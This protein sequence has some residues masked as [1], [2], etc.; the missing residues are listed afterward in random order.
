[1]NT[2]SHRPELYFRGTILVPVRAECEQSQQYL[3]V[4]AGERGSF[5]IKPSNPNIVIFRHENWI[6][7]TAEIINDAGVTYQ[8]DPAV[9]TPPA[10]NAI[11]LE[12]AR[13]ESLTTFDYVDRE[14][15]YPIYF[16][17]KH[18]VYHPDQYSCTD[19]L[20]DGLVTW[21]P[22]DAIMYIRPKE[23]ILEGNY[24]MWHIFP[25]EDNQPWKILPNHNLRQLCLKAAERPGGFGFIR[26]NQI[27]AVICHPVYEQSIGVLGMQPNQE[28]IPDENARMVW[29]VFDTGHVFVG[30][31]SDWKVL[32]D[33]VATRNW[34]FSE[35]FKFVDTALGHEFTLNQLK[36][37][38]HDHSINFH[39]GV[40]RYE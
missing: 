16:D 22:R 11:L 7:F 20:G 17:Y 18:S 39:K 19:V 14:A 35:V 6:N 21:L 8:V 4:E 33:F 34:R 24:H 13:F 15:G 40:Q 12:D 23:D 38:N 10:P 36:I 31:F 37:F 26:S 2:N 5:T 30:E 9:P 3:D 28:F 29:W 25:H 32:Y 27:D 1:M